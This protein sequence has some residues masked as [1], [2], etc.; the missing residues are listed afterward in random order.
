M[1]KII[2]CI[3]AI[4]SLAVYAQETNSANIGLTKRDN[5]DPWTYKQGTRPKAGDLG[6]FVS[7]STLELQRFDANMP[8]SF[9]NFRYYFTNDIVFRLGMRLFKDK[10]VNN[11]EDEFT[12]VASTVSGIASNINKTSDR[13]YYIRPGVEKHFAMSNLIDVYVAA[14]ALLGM[15]RY[16]T[17]NRATIAGSESGTYTSSRSVDYGLGTYIGFQAFVADLPLAIG[18]EVGFLGIGSLWNRTKVIDYA[19]NTTAEYYLPHDNNYNPN[20]SATPFESLDSRRFNLNSNLK[21][22]ICYFFSR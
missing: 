5:L 19:G 16:N 13:Q 18:A 17:D 21:F 11:G 22:N 9:I 8:I 2:T 3:L 10:T 6:F 7:V 15:S 20:F 14:D 12:G 4:L 1:K